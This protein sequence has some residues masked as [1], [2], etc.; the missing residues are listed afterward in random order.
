MKNLILCLFFAL[1][2]FAEETPSAEMTAAAADKFLATLDPAQRTK[3]VFPITSDE[4][5]NF[6]FTPHERAGLPF[7]E[8]SDAQRA[9]AMSLLDSAMSEKGKL[10]LTQVMTLEGILA[11]MEKDPAKRDTG[12]YYIS[13]FG[14]PGDAKGWGWRFEG[15]HCAI[16]ITLVNGKIV[17]DTPSFYGTNPAEVR[18]GTHHIGLRVLAAEE[19]LARALA[20]TLQASGKTEVLFSEKPPGE[21]LT[22]EN[23]TATATAPV[24]IAHAAMTESQ[25]AALLSLISEYTGRYRSDIAAADMA[26]MKAAGI[27]QIRFGWA[28]S[29]KL[30]EGY[31]YRIQGP[32]FLMEVANV[33]D[34]ANHIHCTWRDFAGDFGRDLL[35]EHFKAGAN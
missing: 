3:A 13:I 35:G 28:G 16:N 31:Y 29:T 2:L 22:A 5:E 32:T 25:R 11:E 19:D 1:P 14:T 18:V 4:H 26:K 10:K 34:N 27:D 7:K 17:S 23:R 15:H 8:M 33:K 30:G 24:G 6:H 12:K 20:T 9:A 21:I